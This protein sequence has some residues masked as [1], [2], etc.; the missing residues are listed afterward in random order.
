MLP[1]YL[2]NNMGNAA[3]GVDIAALGGLWQAAVLGVGGLRPRETGIVLDLHLP[4]TWG[5]LRFSVQWRGRTVTVD[6]DRASRST[7]VAVQGSEPMSI[8]LDGG[9]TVRADPG[10]RWTARREQQGW[11]EW[12]RL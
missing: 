3:G 5:S 6:L 8:A 1:F 11:T 2:A 7:A 10:T 12:Q 9:S 4:R